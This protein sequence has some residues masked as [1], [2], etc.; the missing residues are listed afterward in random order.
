M[1]HTPGRMHDT[2]EELGLFSK[3]NNKKETVKN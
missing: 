3:G 1:L 2:Q